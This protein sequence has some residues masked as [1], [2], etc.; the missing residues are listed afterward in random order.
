[1][2]LL[3]ALTIASAPLARAMPTA[4][5]TRDLLFGSMPHPA[6]CH[7]KE[8]DMVTGDNAGDEFGE[9][10]VLSGNGD[11]LAVGALGYARVH[12]W[13]G[14]GY[15]KH[16]DLDKG[17]DQEHNAMAM[18]DDGTII[19]VGHKKDSDRT[20]KVVVYA[21]GADGVYAFHSEHM[22]DSVGDEFGTSVALSADGA[23]LVIGAEQGASVADGAAGY[24]RVL[25]LNGATNQWDKLCDL[26]GSIQTTGD[27][28]GDVVA[29]SGNAK[30][31]GVSTDQKNVALGKGYAQ[32][33]HG[34]GS[35][36]AVCTPMGAGIEGKMVGEHTGDSMALNF[37]GSVLAIGAPS[38]HHD[39]GMARVYDV[40]LE[41]PHQHTQA[42]EDIKGMG[43]YPKGEFAE[44]VALDDTGKV[45]VVGAKHGYAM[46]YHM[47]DGIEVAGTMEY[48][49]A[50]EE[51]GD[52]VDISGNGH[53]IAV[54][55]PQQ[56]TGGAGYVKVYVREGAGCPEAPAKALIK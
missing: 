12:K 56:D 9:A 10:V 35:S 30:V 53:V 49:T 47:V 34:V 24:A 46:L 17:G 26:S 6:E 19:V 33:F 54:S 36:D 18:S 20:G 38:A 13:G 55:A 3:F 2:K 16:Q 8:L 39:R 5:P 44:S 15:V 1:M 31:I 37:D 21:R 41:A 32:L 28:F 23:T 29:I 51:F 48:G 42:G 22:G 45:L 40:A 14:T 7:I 52:Q 50:A 4:G 25:A 43:G 27:Q 11:F